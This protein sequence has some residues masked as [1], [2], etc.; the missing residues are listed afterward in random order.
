MIGTV[1]LQVAGF[2]QSLDQAMRPWRSLVSWA[3]ASELLGVTLGLLEIFRLRHLY[4]SAVLLTCSQY[5]IKHVFHGVDPVDRI[6][7]EVWPAIALARRIAYVLG[8]LGISVS[9]EKVSSRENVS[10]HLAR[11]EMEY[12]C[13]GGWLP[14]EDRWPCDAA[15]KT[16]FQCVSRNSSYPM[17]DLPPF[18]FEEVLRACNDLYVEVD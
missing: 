16:V 15:F 7:Q 12:R 4:S 2:L 17:L 1:L 9:A 10:P 14:D 8:D 3:R 11:A 13:A 18:Y 5:A 6:G